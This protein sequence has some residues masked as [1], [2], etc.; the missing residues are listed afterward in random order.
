YFIADLGALLLLGG[1][2]ALLVASAGIVTRAVVD[3]ER[4]RPLRRSLLQG[5]SA[6]F[7]IEAA[8][9]AHGAVV[10]LIGDVAWPWP[11]A[12]IAAAVV[13]YCLVRT[14]VAHLAVPLLGRQPINPEWSK[15]LVRN[16]P[17][18]FVG[19]TLA[20]AVVEVVNNGIWGLLPVA[21]VPLVSAYRAYRGD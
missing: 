20:A 16:A 2:A 21:A 9:L 18:Y 6:L 15:A 4:L 7:G 3:P 11:A 10:S 14:F 12:P 17:H 19:A 5:A 1:N 13:A 8:A